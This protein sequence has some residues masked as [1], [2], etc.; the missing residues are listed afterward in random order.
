LADVP[1][2][3]HV[4]R[5]SA[6]AKT[7]D[8]LAKLHTVDEREIAA[9]KLA[10]ENGQ[11]PEMKAYGKML[12]Q[13]HTEAEKKVAA[14]AHR[15]RVDL[16]VTGAPDLPPIPPGPDFDKTLARQTVGDQQQTI[17]EV[18]AARDQTDDPELPALLTDLL[19]VL[20][21]HVQAAKRIADTEAKK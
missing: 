21:R 10:Q 5:P 15:E 4:S 6:S 16:A 12:V 7:A 18:T 17:V 19:P 3:A 13:D 1:P 9:G 14:L 20:E 11:S 2:P 8:M